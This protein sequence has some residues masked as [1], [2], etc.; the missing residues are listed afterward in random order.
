MER[1]EIIPT[2]RTS[3]MKVAE[4]IRYALKEDPKIKLI[5]LYESHDNDLLTIKVD[6][7]KFYTLRDS[8]TYN[9]FN[10][11]D[12]MILECEELLEE[13]FIEQIKEQAEQRVREDKRDKHGRTIKKRFLELEIELLAA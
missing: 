11:L 12:K 6:G 4:A 7:K 10:S 1:Y 2:P 9:P 13:E 3:L 5:E 8:D